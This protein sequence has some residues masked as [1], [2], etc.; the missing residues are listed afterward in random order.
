MKFK[1]TYALSIFKALHFSVIVKA[2]YKD[3]NI[4]E[5]EEDINVLLSNGYKIIYPIKKTDLNPSQSLNLYK[6]YSS[7]LNLYN[8]L[9]E[10]FTDYKKYNIFFEYEKI[11]QDMIYFLR[12]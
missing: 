8:C 11:M 5:I 12:K 6:V 2:N 4:Y 7:Y 3:K 10:H 9:K 1:Q